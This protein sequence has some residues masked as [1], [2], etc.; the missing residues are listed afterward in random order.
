[1]SNNLSRFCF[2][3]LL[4][5]GAQLAAAQ[6]P[7]PYEPQKGGPNDPEIA[8]EIGKVPPPIAHTYAAPTIEC[9][10]GTHEQTKELPANA[11]GTR[12]FHKFCE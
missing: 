4:L 5:I 8:K 1:M 12:N 10:A 7:P 9:D 3:G 6:N 11:D 2:A